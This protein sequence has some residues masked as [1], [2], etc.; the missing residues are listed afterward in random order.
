L[1]FYEIRITLCMYSFFTS[2]HVCGVYSAKEL[3]F[4][5]ALVS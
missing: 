4:S 1:E 5:S 2:V 3:M